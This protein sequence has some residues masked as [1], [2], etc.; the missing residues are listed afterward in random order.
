M[1]KCFHYVI[2][3]ILFIKE[4]ICKFMHVSHR[5]KNPINTKY[6]NLFIYYDLGITSFSWELYFPSMKLLHIID[7]KTSISLKDRL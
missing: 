4:F 6:S 2:Y 7:L 1:R 3:F 5:K